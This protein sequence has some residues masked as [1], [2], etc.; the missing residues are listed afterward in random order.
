MVCGVYS[1]CCI[2]DVALITIALYGCMK[3]TCI[4][5]LHT[6]HSI[7]VLYVTA[8]PS[9]SLSLSLHRRCQGSGVGLCPC[10]VT[11]QS[12]RHWE[13]LRSASP[14]LTTPSMERCVS[15]TSLP[16]FSSTPPSLSLSST[17]KHSRTHA[18][19]HSH[20]QSQ[21]L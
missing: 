7:A 13:P 19:A 21:N 2:Q 8:S 4:E 11:M 14:V 12:I 6:V 18:G 20:P 17:H 3:C 15:N 16:L 5:W 10:T 9:P 1:C